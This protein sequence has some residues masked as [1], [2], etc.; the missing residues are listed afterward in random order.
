[1][2]NELIASMI[3]FSGVLVSVLV[4]YLAS[5]RSIDNELR[6]LRIHAQETYHGKVLDARLSSYPQLY[7]LLSDL[8][9]RI[10][11]SG[12][13]KDLLESFIAQADDWDSRNALLMSLHGASTCYEFRAYVREFIQ[14]MGDEPVPVAPEFLKR[15]GLLEF[16]LK[17][18]LGIWGVEGADVSLKTFRSH[19]DYVQELMKL[20]KGT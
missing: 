19:A 13:S 5:K 7:F 3:A 15:I 8:A 14:T 17:G 11:R 2:T 4:S 9:K 1:M 6:K 12:I 16:A 10:R 18:D 20:R